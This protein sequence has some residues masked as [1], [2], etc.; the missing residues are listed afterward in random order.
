VPEKKDWLSQ[1]IAKKLEEK[2][3]KRR[4]NI[5]HEEQVALFKWLRLNQIKYPVLGTIF[6]IPNQ[7]TGTTTAAQ[8]ARFKQE[9]KAAGVWDIF[10]PSIY[11]EDY[12]EN[13]IYGGLW[14]EMK[15]PTG[16]LSDGQ[17]SFKKA[18][19]GQYKFAVCR[20]WVEAASVIC[21]YLE[22]REIDPA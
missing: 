18:L 15:S 1:E 8:G 7:G 22:I 5:E 3:P 20:S 11:A 14:I 17:Q 9:G 21:E 19:E 2:S 4:R 6:A 13:K 10:V 16:R 12:W